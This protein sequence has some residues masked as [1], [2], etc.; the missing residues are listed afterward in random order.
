MFGSFKAIMDYDSTPAKE[1]GSTGTKFIFG[2][3]WN[4]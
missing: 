1:V 2:L 3:G 4:Y